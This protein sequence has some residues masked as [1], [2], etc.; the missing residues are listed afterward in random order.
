MDTAAYDTTNV[1]TILQGPTMVLGPYLIL[2][3]VFKKRA[4]ANVGHKLGIYHRY[5][6]LSQN[7]RGGAPSVDGLNCFQDPLR[8]MMLKLLYDLRGGIEP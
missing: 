1:Q 2:H 8:Q 4:P 7:D 3:L 5:K 6:R